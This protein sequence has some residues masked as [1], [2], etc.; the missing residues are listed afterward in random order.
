[1]DIERYI[2]KLEKFV[3]CPT[4]AKFKSVRHEGCGVIPCLQHE[5]NLADYFGS[6]R[7][8]PECPANFN[9][10]SIRVCLPHTIINEFMFKKHR[11]EILLHMVQFLVLLKEIRPNYDEG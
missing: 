9:I 7:C 6:K 5:T 11:G 4:Y 3:A 8:C 2:A 10:K 1:M